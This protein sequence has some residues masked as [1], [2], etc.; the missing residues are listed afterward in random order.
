MSTDAEGTESA[1]DVTGGKERIKLA[2]EGCVL[3]TSVHLVAANSKRK[4]KEGEEPREVQI[5]TPWGIETRLMRYMPL[6]VRTGFDE[7]YR[8]VDVV[9]GTVYDPA[10]GYSS[11]L[12]MRLT[13]VRNEFS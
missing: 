6:E 11:S 1:D 3:E 8:F 7:E 2:Y 9:T 13:G 12:L 10:T 5:E 4:F